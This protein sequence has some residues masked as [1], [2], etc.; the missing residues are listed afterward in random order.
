MRGT[1]GEGIDRLSDAVGKGRLK[2]SVEVDQVYAHYQHDPMNHLHHP[3][4]GGP[5]YLTNPLFQKSDSRMQKLADDLITEDG[6]RLESG[7]AEA[8][9]E[10]SDDVYERAPWEFGDLRASGHPQVESNGDTVYDRAPNVHR[11]SKEELR[12]K[13]KLSRL[14]WPDRYRHTARRGHGHR[15]MP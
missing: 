4:G 11:L 5:N 1:F 13:N 12:E 15:G 2:G 8:M 10:L 6:S 3:D 14:F 9:E 7:M